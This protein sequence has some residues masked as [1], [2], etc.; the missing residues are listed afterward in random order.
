MSIPPERLDHLEARV[1]DLVIR[2]ILLGLFAYVSLALIRP[3]LPVVIWAIILAVALGPMHAWLSAKMGER[4]KL[5][6]VLVTL[7]SLAVVIGPVAALA[8]NLVE[9][10]YDLVARA[11]NGSLRL[12]ELSERLST[13]PLV[14]DRLQEF[15]SL[16]ASGLKSVLIRYKEFLAPFGVK[17]LGLLSTI[18]FDLFQF[19]LSIVVAGLFLTPGPDLAKWGRRIATR[20]VAPRGEQFV[21][22]ATTTIRNVSRGVVGVALLQSILIGVVLQAAGL[23]SAGLLAFVILVLSILQIGPVLVVLP[24]LIWA[25]VTMTTGG[26][27]LL[28]GLLVPLTVMDNF[29]KPMLM[30]RGLKTPALVIFLGVI[31]GTLTYGLIGLFLGPVVL[32]VFYDLIVSWALYG[33]ASAKTGQVEQETPAN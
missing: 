8:G 20:V 32:A 12:P 17:V 18:S 29:L 25:W 13:L 21:D 16:A 5:A 22:L 1:T 7:V 4:R 33:G 19:I 15:W 2:L 3:F 30:G 6:A 14:G 28:T 11:N 23:P 26:A 24:V 31:G 10:V 27:L 9:T